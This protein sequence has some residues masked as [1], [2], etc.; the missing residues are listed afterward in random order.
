[1]P[2]PEWELIK[3]DYQAWTKEFDDGSVHWITDEEME[4]HK[5]DEEY[6]YNH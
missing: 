5:I 2:I 3:L 4:K 6:W 1:M